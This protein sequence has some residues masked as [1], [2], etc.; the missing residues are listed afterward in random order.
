M[1][2]EFMK[3][4][5]RTC[6]CVREHVFSKKEKCPGDQPEH[7]S[8]SWCILSRNSIYIIA[9]L[10][11]ICKWFD[12]VFSHVFCKHR[13]DLTSLMYLTYLM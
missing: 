5:V 10:V 13:Q 6:S 2:F 3:K 8:E 4:F 1:F 12:E 11:M 7:I 9:M